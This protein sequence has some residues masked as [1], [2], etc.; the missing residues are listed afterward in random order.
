[1]H[2]DSSTNPYAIPDSSVAGL[3]QTESGMLLECA[4][5]RKRTV[6]PFSAFLRHPQLAIP[7]PKCGTRHRLAFQRKSQFRYHA[8]ALPA[9]GLGLIAIYFALTGQTYRT[10]DR[11]MARVIRYFEWSPSRSTI[12]FIE[13]GFLI[14]LLLTPVLLTAF[15]GFRAQLRIIASEGVLQERTKGTPANSP[16]VNEGANHV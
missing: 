16:T 13:A 2:N 8:C 11:V 4:G 9:I 12:S 6:R 15:W 1:M 3:R 5:C 7:C 10:M 14:V